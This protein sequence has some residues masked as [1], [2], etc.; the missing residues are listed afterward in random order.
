MALSFSDYQNVE[1]QYIG[2][3]HHYFI[4]SYENVHKHISE[5]DNI[6]LLDGAKPDPWTMLQ[7]MLRASVDFPLYF[8]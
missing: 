7:F 1:N 5:Q 2:N 3:H 6:T 4:C 8:H